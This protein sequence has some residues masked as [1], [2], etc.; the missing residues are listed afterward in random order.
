MPLTVSVEDV[1]E[2]SDG[3]G[4]LQPHVEDLLLALE[5]DVGGPSDHATKVAL[6]LDV[7]TDTEV[8]GALLDEHIL[9]ALETSVM[10]RIAYHLPWQASLIHRPWPGGRARAPLSF[11][12]EASCRR[13]CH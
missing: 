9:C 3:R 2:L 4:D 7:L 5:A 1:L 10:R 13:G 12:W 11:L 6:G 8:L